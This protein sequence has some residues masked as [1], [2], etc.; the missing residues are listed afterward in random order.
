[1]IKKEINFIERGTKMRNEKDTLNIQTWATKRTIEIKEE[2]NEH[3]TGGM[4]AIE[5]IVLVLNESTLSYGIKEQ[6][7]QDVLRKDQGFLRS[8]GLAMGTIS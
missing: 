7:R 2:I 8:C 5:A 6:I 3:I 4:K 1:M